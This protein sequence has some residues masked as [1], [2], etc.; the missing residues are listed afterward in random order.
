M[1]L[2]RAQNPGYLFSRM[3]RCH[4]PL[5]CPNKGMHQNMLPALN[6]ITCRVGT[7]LV[8]IIHENLDAWIH[9][10][11]PLVYTVK[12]FLK[13]YWKRVFQTWQPVIKLLDSLSYNFFSSSSNVPSI[14]GASCH[15]K[16]NKTNINPIMRK[17]G[18]CDHNHFYASQCNV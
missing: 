13:K 15:C 18:K 10:V 1:F 6:K 8:S 16:K 9:I 11:H 17:S 7:L 4:L 5:H 2:L 12:F 3:Q 14:F